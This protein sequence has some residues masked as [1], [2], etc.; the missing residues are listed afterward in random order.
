MSE[1]GTAVVERYY[2]HPFVVEALQTLARSPTDVP[3]GQNEIE[4]TDPRLGR[5][6]RE[7]V[8]PLVDGLGPLSVHVDE[9]NNLIAR[10]GVDVPSPSVLVMGYTTA[11]HG[12]YTDEAL[13]GRV[14]SGR[15]YGVNE[16]C[17]FGKGTSQNKGALAAVLGALKILA[18]GAARLRGSVVLVVNAES[19][20]S[21]RCSM[22]IFDGHGVRADLGWLAIGSPRLVLGH[23]GRVD[24]LVTVRGAPGHS[25][26]PHRGRNAIW[27]LAEALTRIHGLKQR[28]TRQ[29]PD[30]G[31]EQ[32]EPYKLVTAP[33]APHT[34]PGEAH[35]TLDRRL[36]PET[37][38]DDAVEEVRRA[39]GEIPPYELVVRK[40]A[41][42][43]PYQ[44]PADHPV[45]R[46]L[47]D[48]HRAIRGDPPEMGYVPFA[49]DAGYANARGIPTVMFGPSA[50][51]RRTEGADVLATEF[52]PLS[53]VRDFTK[54]YAR[55]LL[56]CLG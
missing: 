25:S 37:D 39:L 43:R 29:H 20:S 48:A 47:A 10:F 12:N 31:G 9:L 44:V 34:M 35:L 50:P 8:R 5:Y 4:P 46:A 2:D 15:P 56:A 1:P 40:G 16:D 18:D 23:R 32:L 21:H 41:H 51:A 30:L 42:H 11:Q 55:A 17:V 36:L 3:L 54:I 19:Q 53:A 14:A 26:E 28:L 24:V 33:I 7:V 27:G 49:F 52:V 13:E 6:V 38:A 45:V 22:R